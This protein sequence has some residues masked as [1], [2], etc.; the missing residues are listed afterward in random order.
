MQQFFNK[1]FKYMKYL[2]KWIYFT[3]IILLI[4]IY[5]AYNFKKSKEFCRTKNNSLVTKSQKM[6]ENYCYNK[7]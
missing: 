4:F 1:N 2:Q 5:Y 6:G 7:L 3:V